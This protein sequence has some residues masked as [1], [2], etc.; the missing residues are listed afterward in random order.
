MKSYTMPRL[1]ADIVSIFCIKIKEMEF[2]KRKL[3][4]R[5]GII[6][7]LFW[8]EKDIKKKEELLDE[9]TK[10]TIEYAKIDSEQDLI[11]SLMADLEN[12][13]RES[14]LYFDYKD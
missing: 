9:I 8:N 6:G 11:D 3:N 12:C 10:N 5:C 2:K 7:D 13:V 4:E 14:D 1:E